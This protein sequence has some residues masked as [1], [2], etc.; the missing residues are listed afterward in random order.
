HIAPGRLRLEILEDADFQND[1]ER[2]RAVHA[3]AATGARLVM[4]DLG[5][6]YS[7]LLRLRTL[8]FHTVKIDQGLVRQIPGEAEAEADVM[9]GFIGALVRMTQAL[10][11]QVVVEGLETPA[12][13][14]VAAALGANAGQGYALAKP[15]PA[16]DVLGWLR[17]FHPINQE[18]GPQTSLGLRARQW[19][20]DNAERSLHDLAPSN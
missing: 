16:D 7:S 19:V 2:N 12:L 9:I 18:S 3:I 11:L 6:G 20:R 10:G 14:E 4:D 1:T 5:S 17:Q 13:I 8:P 15:M